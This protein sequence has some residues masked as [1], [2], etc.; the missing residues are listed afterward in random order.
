MSEASG[1]A[2][3]PTTGLVNV[4]RWDTVALWRFSLDIDICP[5]C[6][7]SITDLCIDCQSDVAADYDPT[8]ESH[9]CKI[10]FGV[11]SHT[12]HTHCI[13]RWMKNGNSKCCMCERDFETTC[14]K[15]IAELTK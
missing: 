10:S 3:A 13:G 6:R 14:V 11:C 15:S 2:L 8:N 12:Y 1:I 9:E 5:I 4:K 7:K